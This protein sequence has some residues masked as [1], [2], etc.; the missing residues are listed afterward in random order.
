MA[1]LPVVEEGKLLSEA[2]NTVKIQVQQMKRHLVRPAAL[3]TFQS[4]VLWMLIVYHCVGARP[5]HG[6]AEER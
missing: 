1:T 6:C 4:R 3:F 2:L 5:T